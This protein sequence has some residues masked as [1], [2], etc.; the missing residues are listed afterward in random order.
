MAKSSARN[1]IYKKTDYNI[2]TFSIKSSIVL[3]V[4]AVVSSVF[5]P[6]LLSKIGVNRNLAIVLCNII[7]MGFSIA[8]IRFFIESKRGFCKKFLYTYIGFG[9]AFGFISFFLMFLQ[10]YV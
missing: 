8:Y 7:I 6:L 3:I 10:A 2:P 4:S 1:K 5:F 9:S